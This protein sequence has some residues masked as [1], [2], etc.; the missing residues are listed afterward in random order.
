ME[1]EMEPVDEKQCEWGTAPSTS[2]FFQALRDKNL[3]ATLLEGLTK[4]LD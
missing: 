2:G 1:R 3:I 4:L